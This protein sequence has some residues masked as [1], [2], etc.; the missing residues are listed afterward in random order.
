MGPGGIWLDYLRLSTGNDNCAFVFVV[1]DDNH[2]QAQQVQVMARTADKAAVRG[3]GLSAGQRVVAGPL[4]Q[5]MRL[6]SGMEV[7]VTKE[8]AS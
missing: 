6:S 2:I 5:L 1:D 7:V 8:P 4:S 3:N